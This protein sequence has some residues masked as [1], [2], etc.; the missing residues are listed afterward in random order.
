[1]KLPR[2][3]PLSNYERNVQRLLNPP[4]PTFRDR[5]GGV[6]GAVEELFC[7]HVTQRGLYRQLDAA[8]ALYRALSRWPP[9]RDTQE[10]VEHGLRRIA[11]ALAVGQAQAGAVPGAVRPEEHFD[12]YRHHPH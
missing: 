7:R 12:Q 11:E 5:V 9:E 1:M 4:A 2:K 8:G 3:V 6:L 10:F